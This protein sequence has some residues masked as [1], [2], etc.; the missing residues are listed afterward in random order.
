MNLMNGR[1][2]PVL[3]RITAIGLISMSLPMLWADYGD[4]KSVC[5]SG[6][7]N[8]HT[9]ANEYADPD[10]DGLINLYE[11]VFDL[12]PDVDDAVSAE[13]V[14]STVNDHPALTFRRRKSLTDYAVLLQSSP[15][16]VEWITIAHSQHSSSDEGSYEELTW[17]DSTVEMS[18][19]G[20]HYLR[21][22][23]QPTA[24]VNYSLFKPANLNAELQSGSSA[25][26]T[27]QDMS[28][29]ESGFVVERRTGDSGSWSTQHT[30]AAN[31][32]TWT[33]T[34]VPANSNVYYRV[35]ARNT[36]GSTSAAS[37]LT[38]LITPGDS[39]G[40]GLPD[41]META[42]GLD[43][44]D[45]TDATGD[46]DGD[47]IPNLWEHALG[48]DMTDEN[49]R[50]VAHFIVDPTFSTETSTQKKTIGA[51]V[52]AAAGNSSAP[53][54]S[55]IEVRE[56][57]YSESVSLPANKR[58]L[59]LATSTGHPP[60]IR[61]PNGS[62]S[63]TFYGESVVSGFRITHASGQSGKGVHVDLPAPD[64]SQ[65]RVVNCIIHNHDVSTVQNSITGSGAG[66]YQ[67][68]GR[69]VVAH[70]TVVG[71]KAN[72][73]GN[74]LCAAAPAQATIINSIFWNPGGVA[75]EEVKVFGN[76]RGYSNLV[77]D[78][79]ISYAYLEDPELDWLGFL[80]AGSPAIGAGAAA[81]DAPLDIH[82][83]PRPGNPDIG[84][85][86]F[87]DSDADGLSDWWEWYYLGNLSSSATDDPD[88]DGL[89]N[90]QE[91]EFGTSPGDADADNDGANDGQEWAAGTNPHLADTDLDGIPDGYEI[92][93]NLDPL[94]YDDALDDKDGDHIPNLYEYL[95]GTDAN[96]VSSKPAP[97]YTVNGAGGGTHTT[98]AAAVTA[99]NSAS[100]DCKIILVKKGVYNLTT[101]V[102]LGSNKRM[103]LLGEEG[104]SPPE[105]VATSTQAF[106]ISRGG[107][108]VDGLI[109]KRPAFI[110]PGKAFYV[111]TPNQTDPVR[112]VNC[113]VTGFNASNAGSAMDLVKGRLTVDHCTLFGN[114]GHHDATSP[115][116]GAGIAIAL[117]SSA[118]LRN[119]ILWNA[120]LAEGA[121]QIKLTTGAGLELVNSIVLGGEHGGLDDDPLLDRYGC[122]RPGSPAIDGGVVLPSLLKDIHGET[123]ANPPDIGADEYV[124]GDA[125]GLPDW[126]ELRFLGNLSDDGSGD[127]DS[128]GLTT[129]QEFAF[130]SNPAVADTDGDGAS[131]SAEFAAGTDPWNSDSDFDGIP[132]G[133]ELAKG[134]DPLDHRDA[135][136]DKDGDR[137]PNLYEYIRSTDA[138]NATSVPATN[139]TVNPAGGGT[140]TTIAAAVNAAKSASGDCKIILVKSATY[141]ESAIA[142]GTK[143]IMLMGERSLLTPTIATSSANACINLTS[144]GSVVDGLILTHTGTTGNSGITVNM[145]GYRSQA[146]LVNCLLVGNRAAQG[147]GILLSNGELLVDH[148]TLSRNSSAAW[149]GEGGSGR[150]IYVNAGGLLRLRNSIVWN[151]TTTAGSE[152]IFVHASGGIAIS[153][154][155]VLGGEHGSMDDD[156]LL[157]HYGCLRPGSPAID[158]SGG[159]SL[160]GILV[161][162][163]G[164]TRTSPPDIGADE[165]VDSDTDGLPDW[166]E[167]RFLGSLSDDGSGDPDSD[168]LTTAQEFTFGSNSAAADT[169]GD[170]ASDSAEFAAGT[171][172]W[173]SDSDYDSIP[174][175]YELAKGLDPLDHRDALEDKDGDRIPNLYEFVRGTDANDDISFPTPDYVVNPAGGGT[176]TTVSAA[177]TAANGVTAGH[178]II[179]VKSGTYN[180]AVS[181]ASKPILLLGEQGIHPPVLTRTTTSVTVNIGTKNVVVD[182]FAIQHNSGGNERGV[183]VNLLTDDEQARLVN[184]IIRY[185]QSTGTIAASGVYL[186]KGDL[187]LLHCTVVHN[188]SGS[189]SSVVGVGAM[190]LSRMKVVN[191]IIWNVVPWT[192]VAEIYRQAGATVEVVNSIVR[193]GELGGLD[194]NPCVTYEGYLLHFSPAVN[195][196]GVPVAHLPAKDIHGEAR[197]SPA[198]WGADEFVDSDNDFLND[199]W[200][201]RYFGNLSKTA[202]GDDDSPSGDGLWN[203]LELLFD[204][205]PTLPDTNGNSVNDLTEA[206]ALKAVNA[207]NSHYWGMDVD[208][209][210]FTLEEEFSL[211]ADVF[212]PD[213]NGDGLLDGISWRA[214]W[215]PTNMDL[216][217]D[218]LNYAQELLLGTSPFLADSDGDGVPDGEDSFPLDPT[219]TSLPADGMDTTPP[220][221]QLLKPAG[222]VEVL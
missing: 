73:Y 156:P 200:E 168:G 67:V 69:L 38:L 191:S 63:V 181:M 65:A 4:W 166:W 146:R 150:G 197:S 87:V 40:D 130:G 46:L 159:I 50:P 71:N 134:L 111:T 33:D 58:I 188:Q 162:V 56:G 109:L 85:D 32:L 193:G 123:R 216:D 54:Y 76:V 178:R 101:V 141:N 28:A 48:T 180:E 213:T 214:G 128:D 172:P 68:D 199:Q 220:E 49:D 106:S 165:Y 174:D 2:K 171:D 139:Y 86:Q 15:D 183:V 62:V 52:T 84:A 204:F 124:D 136:E 34:S 5:F 202:Y 152:Q 108:V 35:K 95:R 131:D 195:P 17:L 74:G 189:T 13:P 7:V 173:N 154:S 160:T 203:Y 103:M 89:T 98:I 27:W 14:F 208:E 77:R 120:G 42:A 125:D 24:G 94:D 219:Q 210:Y 36:G 100:G 196:D 118:R 148:C 182:G 81:S 8:D 186:A 127:P 169:D 29:A 45:W 144:S 201:L 161:D 113:I 205:N 192:S 92:D 149:N 155:I 177:I 138:D 112:L 116:Q 96:N 198:D 119:C 145:S 72:F 9:V 53:P 170:G 97:D 132:D 126:W 215:N 3:C 104:T 79:T 133:Y 107:V 55:I 157:D 66:I 147:G 22:L 187:T 37:N 122:L 19:V 21:L 93:K 211:G 99:A 179:H 82:G 167:L 47:G 83:E 10:G 140:H 70:C 60:E 153:N 44:A 163:H 142:V 43:L 90:A 51:A 217:G 31:I 39:D 184:C 1:R 11:Y 222:A 110:T 209:D 206:L 143:R 129:A 23:V 117:Y 88:S 135:L 91:Y 151:P 61:T 137:I 190:G 30:T 115:P 78:G 207:W 25:K 114:T 41:S 158:P 26:L 105:V 18:V 64:R 57:V 59:L 218:G 194:A 6:Q 75:P 102:T 212:N 12:D 80:S 121:S 164:E 176:H 16:N 185:N 20:T 221:I 175:G